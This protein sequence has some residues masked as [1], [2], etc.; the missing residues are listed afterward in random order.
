MD[1]IFDPVALERGILDVD[2]R[3]NS[4]AKFARDTAMCTTPYTS[5]GI[6]SDGLKNLVAVRSWKAFTVWRMSDEVHEE[7]SGRERGGREKV[8]TL[9]YLRGT[10]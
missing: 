3:V 4:S 8:A 1:D 10:L 7:Q 5:T 2:G 9:F 6:P